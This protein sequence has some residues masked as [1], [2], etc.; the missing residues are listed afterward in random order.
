[1][2]ILILLLAVCLFSCSNEDNQLKETR[3]FIDSLN[4]KRYDDSIQIERD[5][6]LQEAIIKLEQATGKKD[7]LTK[8]ERLEKA[9]EQFK[10]P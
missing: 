9:K 7:T 4:K 5:L 8:E 10:Q 2:K 3:A 6:K 1:M